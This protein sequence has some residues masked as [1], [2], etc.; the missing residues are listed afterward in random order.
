MKTIS[1][2]IPKLIIVFLF[3]FVVACDDYEYD[4]SKADNTVVAEKEMYVAGEI[5]MLQ[6]NFQ[7]SKESYAAKINGSELQ[8]KALNDALYFKLDILPA[9]DYSIDVRIDGK[10]YKIPIKIIDPEPIEN[11]DNYI[12]TVKNEVTE[13]MN[14][15]IEMNYDKVINGEINNND[16]DQKKAYWESRIEAL[17]QEIAKLNNE[18]KLQFAKDWNANKELFQ[19]IIA[20]IKAE[21]NANKIKKSQGISTNDP[22]KTIF[23]DG[24]TAHNNGHKKTAAYYALRYKFCKMD[25]AGPTKSYLS[26]IGMLFTNPLD[27]LANLYEITLEPMIEWF[28][29][30]K[31]SV[32]KRSIAEMLLD[33]LRG[34]KTGANYVNTQTTKIGF[35]NKQA[36]SFS[37]NVK[38]R[39]VNESDIEANNAFSGFAKSYQEFI[40]AFNAVIGFFKSESNAELEFENGSETIAMNRFMEITNITNSKVKLVKSEYVNDD[41]KLT[42]ETNETTEQEFSFTL[43]YND[44][45]TELS[46]DF[47]AILYPGGFSLIGTWEAVNYFG[48]VIGEWDPSY[49]IS[50]CPGLVTH[51][52]RLKSFIWTFTEDEKLIQK[53]ET[54]RKYYEYE[55]FKSSNCS[56]SNVTIENSSSS[57]TVNGAYSFDGKTLDVIMVFDDDDDSFSI[58]LTFIDANTFILGPGS[59]DGGALFK[60]K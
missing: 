11:I 46:K 10:S 24:K 7:P 17:S 30:E 19:E 42:F 23:S 3:A 39:N 59:G 4:D 53:D 26:K 14:I 21:N 48:D 35:I 9:G 54:E 50:E 1:W 36:S 20:L 41:W 57:E 8:L 29:T 34:S 55:G 45:K 31:S 47:D 37:V 43:R 12:L 40:T 49:S 60:R 58:S 16:A 2:F 27:V 51:D 33:D 6:L 56:Y 32:S 28:K 38:Y 15:L 22:C 5:G 13:V 44:G 25:I 52:R 18:Q